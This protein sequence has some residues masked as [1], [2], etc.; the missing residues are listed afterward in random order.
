M[1]APLARSGPQRRVATLKGSTDDLN[2][3]FNESYWLIYYHIVFIS[4]LL[5]LLWTKRHGTSV[6]HEAGT[7]R[8][9]LCSKRHS[10]PPCA[11]KYDC[12]HHCVPP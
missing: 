5:C 12:T 10:V 11:A 6:R 7:D 8:L 1:H 2:T 3:G 4:S 9:L